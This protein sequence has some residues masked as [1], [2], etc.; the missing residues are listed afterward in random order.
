ME[1][2]FSV[3][4]SY[5]G[6]LGWIDYDGAEKKAEVFLDDENGKA[7]AEKYLSTA[8]EIRVPHETL[9]DFTTQT[10]E[11]LADVASFQLAITRLWNE[12]QVHVDWSRPVDYV[13]AHPTL[14]S[15]EK[16]L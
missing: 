5:N 9:R 16:C 12:T 3:A 1:D 7:A 15:T 6:K 2:K 4:I 8:H 10:V 11:P 14:E 13:K